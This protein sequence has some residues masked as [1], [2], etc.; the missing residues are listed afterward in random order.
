MRCSP[1]RPAPAAT[2][3]SLRRTRVV[4]IN[5]RNRLSPQLSTPNDYTIRLPVSISNVRAIRLSSTEFTNARYVIDS[6]N[7]KLD[8]ESFVVNAGT[9]LATLTPGHYNVTDLQNE[10]DIQLN[11]AMGVGPGTVFTV[12]Y[13]PATGRFNFTRTDGGT[14]SFRQATG[15]NRAQAPLEQLGLQAVDTATVGSYLAPN[16]ANVQGDD[17]TLMVLRGLGRMDCTEDISDV[18][19]K[20]IWPVPS[21]A[22]ANNAYVYVP[23]EFRDQ[24]LFRLSELRVQ[25]FRPTGQVCDWQGVEHSFTLD[26]ESDG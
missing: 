26:I 1:L 7:N 20:L 13:N 4:S 21:R 12:S 14:F 8:F 3:E 18:F 24:P 2:A 15:A 6:T 19:A 16:A 10:L 17:Y 22:Q 9:K 23:V 5:S 25:F 11:A